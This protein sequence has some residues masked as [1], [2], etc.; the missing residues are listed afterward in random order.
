MRALGLVSFILI[1]VWVIAHAL[2]L[3]PVEK[4]ADDALAWLIGIVAIAA[5][6]ASV[7][8][9]A[10]GLV[11]GGTSPAWLKFVQQARTIAT[12]IGSGLV[13]VGLLHYRDTEPDGEIR[14]L[15]LG[16]L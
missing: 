12:V 11:L 2:F 16:V 6:I 5:V 15:V 7:A 13:V 3:G 1:A 4:A 9:I 8:V 14:W 10:C